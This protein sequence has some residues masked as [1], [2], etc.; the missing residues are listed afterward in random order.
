MAACVI[1]ASELPK[2]DYEID[3]SNRQDAV[4]VDINALEAAVLKALELERVASAVLSISIV[5]NEEIHKLN[6]EHLEHDYPTDVISF[7][8]DFSDEQGSEFSEDEDEEDFESD[9][10]QLAEDSPQTSGSV[11]R[12]DGAMIEGE[13]IASAE[14]AASMAEDGQWSTQDELTLYVV[15]GLL[16]ICGY[17]DLTDDEKAIMRSRERTI[18]A[19]LGL[20]AVYAEDSAGS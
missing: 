5:S 6:R 3:I 11:L 10:A 14:M 18:M 2:M 1:P 19:S 12:A 4:P 20:K 7:Q 8:L 15:H 17:D 16:H 13:I 9:D